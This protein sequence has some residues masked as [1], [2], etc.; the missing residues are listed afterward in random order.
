MYK[1]VKYIAV[2]I[3]IIM[4]LGALAPS[5]YAITGTYHF[6]SNEESNIQSEDKYT[7]RDD[8]FERSSFLGCS[9]LEILSAQVALASASWYGEEKDKYE[10]D[11]SQN[12]HNIVEMLNNMGFEN[13]STNKYYT[14]EKE[15]NSAGVAVGHKTITVNNKDYTLL[16]VIPRSA[17]YKQEWA[18]NFT[19]GDGDIHEGFKSARDEILRYVNKYI[20]DNNIQGELKVWTTGH[21]RG[22]AI[23]NMLGGFFAGGGIKYF[24]DN[25][26]ITPEDVYCYTYAT[27]RPIKDG[28]DKNIELTVS[29]NRTENEYKNDTPGEYFS[30]TE[31]GN[32]NVQSEVYGGI[33]NFLSSNDIFTLLPLETWG[34]THYGNDIPSNH[35][36]ISEEAMLKELKDFSSF[37]YNKYKNGG[38]PNTFE[39]KE[40]DLKTLKLVKDN[41]NYSAMDMSTLLNERLNGLV[42]K[43]NNNTK[44]K[45]EGYQETLKSIAGI[46]GMS[47]T[48]FEEDFLEE[49]SEIIKPLV[50]SYLAYVSE[51][52][53]KEGKVENETEAVTIALEQLLTYFTGE[54][55]N[56]ETFCFDDFITLLAKYISDNEDQPIAD[57]VISGIVDLVPEE[58]KSILAALKAFDKSNSDNNEATLENSF[59]S[60]LK[61]CYYGPDPESEAALYYNDAS[62]VRGV[63]YALLYMGLGSEYPEIIPILMDNNYNLNGKGKFEDFIGVILNILKTVKDDNGYIIKK[64]STL[65]EMGDDQLIEVIDSI[66]KKPLEKAESLY[67]TDYKNNFNKHIETLK[68]NIS[69][70]RDIV[71]YGLL[72]ED[73]NYSAEMDVKNLTTFIGNIDIIPLAHYN[74]IYLAYA[75]A[76]VNYDCGYE[77]HSESDSQSKDEETPENSEES[78]NIDSTENPVNKDSDKNNKKKSINP[79][80]G[81]N[82]TMWL[83]LMIFSAL[84]VSTIIWISFKNKIKK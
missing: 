27:P 75:K 5:V 39:R 26:S 2:L 31:G 12:S 43:A 34:F 22:A 10:I 52:L 72:Y 70:A 20:K 24:G 28:T 42:Y 76:G 68:A 47:M 82:I 46:Y 59:K 78:K 41:G 62:Q 67:G 44:Y 13:V 17:G 8:C 40:F 4:V 30:Y 63:L 25:V 61:A 80:T 81:D 1:S 65:S 49:N 35:G 18:G 53:Q 64:Y 15:E 84:G 19:V 69:K 9:H 21:S 55:I 3:V 77:E 38:D 83:G 6:T 66:F 79:K 57:T 71:L 73:G 32:V 16:A 45:E 37:A 60:F 11:Y 14:L 36:K 54:E 29:A 33:R 58:Y 23:A 51:R 50:Y 56:S 7:Y 48:L 74:E